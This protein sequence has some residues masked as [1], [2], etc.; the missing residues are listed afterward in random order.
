MAEWVEKADRVK[1]L[2]PKP[3]LEYAHNNFSE[4]ALYPKYQK[5]WKR[6]DAFF[7]AGDIDFTYI[8]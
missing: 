2:K 5:F 1:S 8:G 6:I 7:E 3:M 4:K